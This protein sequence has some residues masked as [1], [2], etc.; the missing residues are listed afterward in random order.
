MD[1]EKLIIWLD[2][3]CLELDGLASSGDDFYTGQLVMAQ[4]LLNRL[5]NGDF[6]K[7]N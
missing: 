1:K 3:T 2:L 5:K 7:E 6:D 4:N